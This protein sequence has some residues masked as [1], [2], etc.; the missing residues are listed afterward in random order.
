M[1]ALLGHDR[2]AGVVVEVDET[3]FPQT[4]GK[5]HIDE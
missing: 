4:A 1:A 2:S 5:A 3:A